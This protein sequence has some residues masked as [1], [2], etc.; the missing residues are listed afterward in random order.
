MPVIPCRTNL[1]H[2]DR[3]LY[4]FLL[5]C[6]EQSLRQGRSF[7]VSVSQQIES[8][9][10][11]S[12]LQN[13]SSLSS[14][15]LH[16]YWENR[17]KKEAVV[18]IG[19]TKHL[20]VKRGNRFT[21]SQNFIQNCLDKTIAVGDLN[22]PWSGPHFFSGFTFFPTAQKN[23][24]PFPPA[25]IFLP[26]FQ[27]ARSPEGCVLVVNITIDD[28]A[29]VEKILE[30]LK[31]QIETI[32]W[33][34]KKGIDLELTP[35]SPGIQPIPIRKTSEF[36]TAV[37]SVLK[38]IQTQ[39]LSKIVLAHSLDVISP[40]PFQWVN[41]LARLRQIHPDCY[42]FSLSNG[43]GTSFIGASPERLISIKNRYLLTDALA[44]SSPRGKTEFEDDFFANQLLNSEKE[45]REHQAVSDFICQR[46]R[47]LGLQPTRSPLQLL[48][49][50]N[51][52]HLWTPI[53]A[54]L[55]AN[56]R[57]LDIVAKLHPTPAV[58]GVPTQI[59]CEKIRHYETFDRSLYAAPLGWVDARGN[60]EFIVGIRSAL[61]KGDRARLYAGAGIVEGSN[62]DKELAEVQLK[63]QTMLKALI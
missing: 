18:A 49:L 19:S 17:K 44:G 34:S 14:S 7:V 56:V 16:F 42:I 43:K 59:A 33:S 4:Q 60:G 40:V 32:D 22:L 63:L 58:A 47:A 54:E 39:R 3:E 28:R 55:P 20:I 51:I 62:P 38:S 52:Q 53:C 57:P 37:T 5:D 26:R 13:I 24:S 35:S 23:E 41:S 29:N 8:I 15:G 31:K 25:T 45:R 30:T 2:N 10:P 48:Q 9:D 1:L 46:L 36:T 21:K 50:S 11:L 27:I 12:A 61:I 6:H